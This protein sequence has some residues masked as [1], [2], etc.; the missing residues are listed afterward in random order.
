MH[1][2]INNNSCIVCQLIYTVV[3]YNIFMLGYV[4]LLKMKS[5]L[6]VVFHVASLEVCVELKI[7]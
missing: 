4:C 2:G 3:T 6:I 1:R 7:F 5:Y